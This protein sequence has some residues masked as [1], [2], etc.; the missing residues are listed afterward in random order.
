MTGP[1]GM[2]ANKQWLSS[3]RADMFNQIFYGCDAQ[4]AR[5]ANGSRAGVFWQEARPSTAPPRPAAA[6]A[7][8]PGRSRYGHKHI[9]DEGELRAAARAAGWTEAHGCRVSVAAFREGTMDPALAALDDE[10]HRD[11]SIYVEL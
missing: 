11:E 1:P 4:G 5:R 3:R 6:A 10:V 9:Y 2:E 7:A 8:A